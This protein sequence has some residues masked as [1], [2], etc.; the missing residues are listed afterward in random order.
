MKAK[1]LRT[2]PELA[3]ESRLGASGSPTLRFHRVGSN[4]TLTDIAE[5][6]Y[7]DDSFWILLY[8]ANAHVLREAGGLRPGQTLYVPFL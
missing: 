5:Q 7:G 4:E 3:D 6:Y 1:S 8:G 2:P